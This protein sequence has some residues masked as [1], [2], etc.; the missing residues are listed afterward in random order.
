MHSKLD[1]LKAHLEAPDGT[2]Y[3]GMSSDGHIICPC[4][5]T[6]LQVTLVIILLLDE[7]HGIDY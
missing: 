7:I 5:P 6:T 2:Q 1:C 4:D 3:R